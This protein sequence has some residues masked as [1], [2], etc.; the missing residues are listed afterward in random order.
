MKQEATNKTIIIG[1]GLSGL[2][3]GILLQKAR[4]SDNVVIYDLNRIPGGFCTSFDKVTQYEG[5]KIK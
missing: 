2:I 1:A 4:P 3:H 5:E